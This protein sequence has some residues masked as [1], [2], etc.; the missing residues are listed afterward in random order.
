MSKNDKIRNYVKSDDEEMQDIQLCIVHCIACKLSEKDALEYLK[1]KD[2]EMQRTK[3]YEYR[4]NKIQNRTEFAHNVTSHGFLEQHII[5]I[6]NIEEIE[7]E[8]WVNYHKEEEPLK[9]SKILE[10]ILNM[11]PFITSAYEYITRIIDEQNRLKKN[12]R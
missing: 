6:E 9:K 5:R 12:Q 8:Q 2:H 10:R 11:Q 1:S 7:R 4:K 3:Y